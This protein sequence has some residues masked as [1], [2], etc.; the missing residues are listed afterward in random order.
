M[1]AVC[2]GIRFDDAISPVVFCE[3]I[4]LGV[5]QHQ[6]IGAEADF[7]LSVMPDRIGGWLLASFNALRFAI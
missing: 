1:M 6:L 5:C 4:Q 2:L 3:M 7:H